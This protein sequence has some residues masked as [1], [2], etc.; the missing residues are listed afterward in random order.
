VESGAEIK[1]PVVGRPFPKGS[2]GRKPGA[3]NRATLVAAALSEGDKKELINKAKELAK[4]GNVQMLKMFLPQIL[5]RERLI[6][7]ELPN[8]TAPDHDPVETLAR[9]IRAVT[10]G[11]ISPSEGVAVANLLE[12]YRRTVELS[13]LVQRI[14]EL[15]AALAKASPPM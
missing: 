3:R 7:I 10:E 4:D 5:P 15:E 12:C 11:K 6:Q 13:K 14:D 8:A 1:L 9:V 2:G